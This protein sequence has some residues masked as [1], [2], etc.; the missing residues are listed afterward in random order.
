MDVACLVGL[1]EIEPRLG[2]R[3]AVEKADTMGPQQGERSRLP[4]GAR[5]F[6]ASSSSLWFGFARSVA[7]VSPLGEVV[8][9]G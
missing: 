5:L 7:G 4:S 6:R 9:G 1:R 2:S 3:I 8:D